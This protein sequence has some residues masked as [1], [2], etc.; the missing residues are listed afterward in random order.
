VLRRQLD[1]W[2]LPALAAWV[3]DNGEAFARAAAHPD[4]G[5]TVH[6]RLTSV[7]GLD[8]IAASTGSTNAAAAKNALRG[9]PAISISV[10]SGKRRQ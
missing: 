8:A 6:I 7:P 1:A 2:V 9:T 4:P 10:T 3:R 5:L